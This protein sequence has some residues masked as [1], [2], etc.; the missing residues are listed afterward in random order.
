MDKK[1]MSHS[2]AGRLGGIETSRRFG[3]ERCPHCGQLMSAGY[4]QELG[5]R[6]GRIGGVT[7]KRLYGLD[8]YREI[9]KLGGRP[10][11]KPPLQQGTDSP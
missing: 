9:G 5:S 7:T 11:R 4:M 6:G 1:R 2:E 8:H 3:V 10:R